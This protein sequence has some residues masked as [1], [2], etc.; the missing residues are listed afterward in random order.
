MLSRLLMAR[1]A[2]ARLGLA[3]LPPLTGGSGLNADISDKVGADKRK[4]STAKPDSTFPQ[5][6]HK[7]ISNSETCEL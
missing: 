6:P 1:P 7:F 4:F 2:L 3:P 5:L